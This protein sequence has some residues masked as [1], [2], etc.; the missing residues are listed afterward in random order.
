M[1]QFVWDYCPSG[2]C[3][4]AD[5]TPQPHERTANAKKKIKHKNLTPDWPRIEAMAL[6]TRVHWQM[7]SAALVLPRL[8]AT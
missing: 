1:D 6:R 3:Q 2:C 7:E 5:T 4:R 8:S